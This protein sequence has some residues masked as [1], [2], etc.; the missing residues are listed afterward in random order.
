M[1][2]TGIMLALLLVASSAVK[3]S[4][5]VTSGGQI[6][7]LAAG[8][9][10]IGMGESGTADNSGSPWSIFWNPASL[11]NVITDEAG[12]TYSSWMDG[13]SYQNM[14][15]ARPLIVE[16]RESALERFPGRNGTISESRSQSG[17][18]KYERI[19]TVGLGVTYFSTV[20]DGY[21]NRGELTGD[22]AASDL[23]LTLSFAR[24]IMFLSSG[25]N[26][27]VLNETLDGISA[28]G[29][30]ADLGFLYP[31]RPNLVF[32]LAFQNLGTGLTFVSE[33][34]PLPMTI[35]FGV[36]GKMN[37]MHN[38][39]TVTSELMK[40]SEGESKV[41]A[42]IEYQL[43]KVFALRA[44]YRSGEDLGSGLKAGFGL[45]MD[46]FTIDYAYAGLG[47]FGDAH[48]LSMSFRF[49]R[50]KGYDVSEEALKRGMDHYEAGNWES[51]LIEFTEALELNP[52]NEEA[53][54]MIKKINFESEKKRK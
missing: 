21:N 37:V 4:G 22:V 13:M 2:I 12:F 18:K 53:F 1:K 14:V 29:V 17:W 25:L 45:N 10:N 43:G 32:G 7:T 23:G 9:R 33:T 54:K 34:T 8:P 28:T 39:L 48:R 42:G 36:S 16:S 24:K 11:V 41:S 35:R 31:V 3:V 47:V 40:P 50:F 27:K 44:G 46:A 51:A 5:A 19:G 49:G 38:R 52:M 6:L 30:A 20:M 15:Y 26:V